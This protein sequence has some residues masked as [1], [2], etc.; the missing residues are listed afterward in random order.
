MKEIKNW[1]AVICKNGKYER[2][3]PLPGC[4]ISGEIDGKKVII[5]TSMVD[6][7]H[8]TIRDIRRQFLLS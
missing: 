2:A 6:L 3:L 7:S 8:L 4:Y 5:E 1:E